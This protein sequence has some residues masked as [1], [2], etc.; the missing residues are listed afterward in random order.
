VSMPRGVLPIYRRLWRLCNGV[1]P[2]L[3]PAVAP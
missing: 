3:T 2:A 1:D